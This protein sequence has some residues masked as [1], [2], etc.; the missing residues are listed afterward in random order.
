MKGMQV[1]ATS[2]SFFIYEINKDFFLIWNASQ[3][4]MSS[5]YRVHADLLCVVPILVNV[6]LT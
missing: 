3:I 1:I 4:S 6:L 5:L 2:S